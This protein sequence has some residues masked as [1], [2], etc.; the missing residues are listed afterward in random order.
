[1]SEHEHTS[2]RKA[3]YTGLVFGVIALGI[4]V[5]GI[6]LLTNRHVEGKEGAKPA[7]G[8]SQ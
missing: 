3:A 4:I 6:V 1:M 5:Y 7:A 2:D 8:S